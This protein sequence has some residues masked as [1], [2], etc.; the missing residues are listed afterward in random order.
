LAGAAAGVF[1]LAGLA[2]LGLTRGSATGKGN[3]HPVQVE[4]A[5]AQVEPTAREEPTAGAERPSQPEPVA[6]REAPAPAAARAQAPILAARPET[7]GSLTADQRGAQRRRPPPGRLLAA[8]APMAVPAE[9]PADGS[10]AG[11]A[12]ASA[13]AP[14]QPVR[15]ADPASEAA[16]RGARLHVMS[17]PIGA[18]IRLA[19][20]SVGRA[21]LTTD[22]LQPERDY[23]LS[24]S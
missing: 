24:A 7:K 10:S 16:E 18:E 14:A 12:A 17:E 5:L 15:A 9:A 2:Y 6:S 21:P 20:R 8:S 22:L 3:V 1:A 11:D 4:T 23:E 19:G 13:A